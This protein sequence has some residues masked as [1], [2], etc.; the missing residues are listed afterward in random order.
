MCGGDARGQEDLTLKRPM[1][2]R[3]ERSPRLSSRVT[4]ALKRGVSQTWDAKARA[5]H[6]LESESSGGP[7]AGG[8]SVG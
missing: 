2:S 7:A 8:E 3:G 5:R 6:R 1:S 4:S